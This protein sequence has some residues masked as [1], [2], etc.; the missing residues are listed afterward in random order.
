MSLGFGR[1]IERI[2]K[3]PFYTCNT[4]KFSLEDAYLESHF[5]HWSYF[6]SLLCFFLS[7]RTIDSTV[8]R[9]SG[10]LKLPFL[11]WD[12]EMD[13]LCHLGD[14]PGKAL[15]KMLG[16]WAMTVKE[17]GPVISHGS[18]QKDDYLLNIPLIFYCDSMENK[19]KERG[20]SSIAF[21]LSKS[22]SSQLVIML[23]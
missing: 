7:F 20:R 5:F 12:R 22:D 10:I 8:S 15:Y 2:N 21:V 14:F 4:R 23:K 13:I 1:I 6:L 11:S 3:L 17:W 16:N 9:A 18:I 19:K